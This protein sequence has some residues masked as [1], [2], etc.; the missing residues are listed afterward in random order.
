MTPHE[1]KLAIL[2]S[3]RDLWLQLVNS[4]REAHRSLLTQDFE[5]FGKKIEQ[6]SQ[7]CAQLRSLETS[8]ADAARRASQ[9]LALEDDNH[10]DLQSVT[11]EIERVRFHVRYANIVQASL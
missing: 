11:E 1:T 9:S 10:P 5:L 6:Q 2:R 3:K 8:R 4:I 7:L